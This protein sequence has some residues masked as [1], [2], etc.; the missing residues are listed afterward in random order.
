MSADKSARSVVIAPDIVAN[1]IVLI[2]GQKVLLDSDLA[3]MYGVETRRLNEQVRRNL[4]RFP[5][6]FMF[7]LTNEEY[8]ALMSQ[9]ATSKTG[10][11]GRRKLPLAFTEHGA[12]MAATVLSS[13]RAVEVSLYVVRAFVQLREVLA[14]HKVL[15]TKLE[16]LE[17]KTELMALKHD[18]LAQNTRAQLKQAFDAIRELMTPPDPPK[19]RSIGFIQQKN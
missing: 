7:T 19:K 15:A 1:R 6:D 18:A 12:L 2:R 11:G 9:N 3:D 4:E 16:A 8:A 17:H 5:P 14:T 13:P 10:R